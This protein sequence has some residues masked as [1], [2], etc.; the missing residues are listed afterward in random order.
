M[1]R[2]TESWLASSADLKAWISRSTRVLS[3]SV[4][5]PSARSTWV[6]T[7]SVAPSRD[8]AL[9][10]LTM[11]AQFHGIAADANQLAHHFGRNDE[12]FDET[13][14]LLAAKHLGL[15]AKVSVQPLERIAQ[16][17]IVPVVQ[18]AFR[19]VD[20]FGASLRGGGGFGSTGRG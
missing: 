1:G 12:A 18:A 5:S 16:M 14:L 9:I 6:S 4:T 11:L 19:V 8:L 13:T 2:G 7:A 15:K 17:V 10:G 3:S 20:D